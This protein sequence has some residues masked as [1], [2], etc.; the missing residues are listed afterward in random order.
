MYIRRW[1]PM[2]EMMALQHQIGR[3]MGE[4][5]EKGERN[6][7]DFGAWMP[8]VDM[9]EETDKV[10]LEM[11]IPGIKKDDIE[12]NI[13]N[14]IITVRGEKKFEKDED[15]GNY[16]KIERAYGKFSRSFSL[17]VAVK[18]DSIDATLK[19][20]ILTLALPFAEEAKP[21]KITIKS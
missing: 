20:G 4:T 7:L 2:N 16:H 10:V 15:K 8:P 17:P 9:R 12:I 19:D 21:K 6:D 11:E 5:L 14:S 13:E 1:T 18:A 3:L